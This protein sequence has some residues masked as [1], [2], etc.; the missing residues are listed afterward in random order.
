MISVKVSNCIV[1]MW[2]TASVREVIDIHKGDHIKQQ[3]VYPSVSLQIIS[4]LTQLHV[5]YSYNGVTRSDWVIE[6]RDIPTK[7]YRNSNNI[8]YFHSST[9]HPPS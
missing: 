8:P 5:S 4:Y 9:S 2:T 6:L 7:Q 3:V 1:T